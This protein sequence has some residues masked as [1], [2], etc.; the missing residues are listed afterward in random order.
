ML[1]ALAVAFG[2]CEKDRFTDGDKFLLF[3]P[4]VT[5][6][7]PS[8]NMT[9]QPTYHGAKPH[10]FK[11]YNVKFNGETIQ[12]ECFGIEADNGRLL[13]TDT[14][15]LAVGVYSISISC[16]SGDQSYEFPDIIK[17]NMMKPVPDGVNVEPAEIV[18][19]LT[20]STTSTLRKYSLLLR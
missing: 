14:D 7:G 16:K 5:D 9:L 6:I 4:D 1:L 8:T 20:R 17:V 11:V 15:G 19:M 12:T 13:I 3:Y 18:L 10:D 2:S